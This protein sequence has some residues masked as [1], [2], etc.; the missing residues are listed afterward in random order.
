[1]RGGVLGFGIF[2]A[3]LA[4]G[5]AAITTVASLS[6]GVKEGLVGDARRLLGGDLELR[7]SY[8]P[9]SP[10]ELALLKAQGQVA[11]LMRL[12]AMA[13]NMVKKPTAPPPWWS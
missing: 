8:R 4:L 11:S 3:C 2:L 1:M 12:R 13:K 9:L 10:P 5:V 7:R 6:A